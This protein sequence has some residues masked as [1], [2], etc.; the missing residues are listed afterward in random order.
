MRFASALHNKPTEGLSGSF[1]TL[2]EEDLRRPS[3]L[4]NRPTDPDLGFVRRL[5]LGGPIASS[6]R[7]S[8]RPTPIALRRVAWFTM[9]CFARGARAV[10]RP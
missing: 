1:G 7:S 3:A 10:D 2:A 8:V 4:P 9:R 5:P 6:G